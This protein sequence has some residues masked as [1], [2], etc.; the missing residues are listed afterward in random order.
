MTITEKEFGLGYHLIT[1]TNNQG[2]QLAVTDLGARIVQLNAQ[3][4]ELILGFDSAQEYLTKDSYIGAF[5]GRTA[6]R[7]EK[8]QFS[9]HDQ[10]YQLSTD[11]ETGH[12]LHGGSPGFELKKWTYQTMEDEQESSV[13][14]TV[15]SPDG[16]HGFPGNLSVEVCYTLTQDNVWYVTTQARSDKETLFNPTN[17]VY[18]NLTGDVT[19]P[20]DQHTLWLDSSYFAPLRADSIPIGEK[21]A[22]LG[23]PFNFQKPQKLVNVFASNFEQKNLFNGIDH[24]FFLN[25]PGV[26]NISAYL[27][28][29]DE[30]IK[31][32]IATDSPSIVLFTANFGSNTPEM[33]G[34]KLVNHG[35]I[36]FETQ[37]APAAERYPTFGDIRLAPHQTFKTMTKFK[38]DVRKGY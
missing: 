14:F 5:I 13:K 35:G 18:F 10:V 17:H 8:G 11:P 12:S 32:S 24:P 26:E 34:K 30:K 33:R 21:A 4:K 23:T 7:I 22:V 6:G 25:K 28:S 9:L 2:L 27:L 37:V 3:Q 20:I 38:I 1:L 15:K 19:Q 29:P 16:E 31:V 36:T